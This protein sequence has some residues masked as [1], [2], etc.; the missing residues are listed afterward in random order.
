VTISPIDCVLP[1]PPKFNPGVWAL[2]FAA[3]MLPAVGFILS[4]GNYGSR[5]S[6]SLML[7]A[8]APLGTRQLSS[9]APARPKFASVEA[10][11]LR[12]V[13]PYPDLVARVKLE[14]PSWLKGVSSSVTEQAG[15]DTRFRRIEGVAVEVT[16]AQPSAG[17]GRDRLGDDDPDGD[18]IPS[19][20]D[21][22]IGAKKTALL[23]TPYVET[24]RI[25]DY[26]SGDMPR[27]EGVCTDVIVRAMRN[28][29]Y[30]LQSL[31]QDDRRRA[32]AAYPGIAKAD[33]NID[34]RRV[35]NL[36]VYFKRH[37][38]SLQ[39]RGV[40]ASSYLPGD[41]LFFDTMG[42]S[43]PAH[44]GIVSDRLGPSGLPLVINSWTVGYVTQEMDLLGSVPVTHRFRVGPKSRKN[45][46]QA[47]KSH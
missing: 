3:I 21:I 44:V 13:G 2:W 30:D 35:R 33:R 14:S 23:A 20:L 31:L 19:S 7:A 42:D 25:L 1:N 32:P 8:V 27:N 15:F 34:H 24:Y 18:G 41:V 16:A 45:G 37:F 39:L 12:D 43:R 36:I 17:Q 9:T 47:S 46:G 26:P 5:A 38:E 22:L 11:I 6:A 40:T 4:G 10:M 29:G 28:A